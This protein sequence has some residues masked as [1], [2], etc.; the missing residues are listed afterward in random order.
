MHQNQVLIVAFSTNF[1]FLRV[2]FFSGL[3]R[4]NR[5]GKIVVLAKNLQNAQPPRART[6]P[7]GKA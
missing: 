6:R 1:F 4:E 7:P 2:I 3:W 5:S